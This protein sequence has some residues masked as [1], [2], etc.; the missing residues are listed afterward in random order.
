MSRQRHPYISP[1]MKTSSVSPLL[2]TALLLAVPASA[3][4]EKA[5]T[6]DGD[7]MKK[8]YKEYIAP[9]DKNGDGRLDDDEK[10][11]AHAAMREENNV[12]SERKK[13]ILKRFDKDADGKLNA[14]ERAEAE[15][16][17]QAMEEAGPGKMRERQLKRYD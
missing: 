10:A 7:A 4:K 14:A 17:R 13:E 1:D 8:S 6:K 16:A 2:L 15:K 9:Y 5:M 11:A 12:E 3:Q